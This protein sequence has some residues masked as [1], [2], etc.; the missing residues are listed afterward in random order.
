MKYIN[1]LATRIAIVGI[2]CT[3][4]NGVKSAY[5]YIVIVTMH[6]CAPY[7]KLEPDVA[8]YT[9]GYSWLLGLVLAT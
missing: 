6:T 3:Q 7:I 4:V 1:E 2:T 9:K 5:S 8:S